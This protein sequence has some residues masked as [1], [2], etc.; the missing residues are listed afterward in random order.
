MTACCKECEHWETIPEFRSDDRTAVCGVIKGTT[1]ADSLAHLSVPSAV[2]ITRADF[3]CTQF[4]PWNGV[5]ST[6][7]IG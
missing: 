5:Y 3:G 2:L 7:F 6:R 1:A 4:K